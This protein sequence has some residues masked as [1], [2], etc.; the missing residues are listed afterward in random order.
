MPKATTRKPKK[1]VRS[2]GPA[3]T[4]AKNHR[5]TGKK[6]TQDDT[7]PPVPPP[8]VY[9][10]LEDLSLADRIVD[11]GGVLT[12]SLKTGDFIVCE[13]L[14]CKKA[15][16][17]LSKYNNIDCSRSKVAL[18]EELDYI[19]E[20]L[21]LT[22]REND[23]LKVR[24]DWFPPKGCP[25]SFVEGVKK[26]NTT[27][28]V[29]RST[30]GT[31]IYEGG[32]EDTSVP[33]DCCFH[34]T[35]KVHDM[36]AMLARLQLQRVDDST[37]GK[38]HVVNTYASMEDIVSGSSFKWYNVSAYDSLEEAVADFHDSFKKGSGCEWADRPAGGKPCPPREGALWEV[39]LLTLSGTLNP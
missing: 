3:K 22:L 19:E 6:S 29:T 31:M 8:S 33:Y 38:F 24:V 39:D 18:L 17:A 28:E 14:S 12:K 20:H 30:M 15:V 1:A 25:V 36:S 34:S 13:D 2:T 32:E 27:M 9:R 35:G 21:S 5:S 10:P 11:L 23:I 16:A 7:P 4:G 26:E 37:E